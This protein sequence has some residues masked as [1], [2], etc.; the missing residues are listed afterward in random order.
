VIPSGPNL[1]ASPAVWGPRAE[2]RR[3]VRPD[4]M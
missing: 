2:I 1:R 4:W 3:Y